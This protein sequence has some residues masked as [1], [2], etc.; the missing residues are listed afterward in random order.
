MA[1]GLTVKAIEERIDR[2]ALMTG[3]PA[4]GRE[5][6]AGMD[7]RLA[8]VAGRVARLSQD[9]KARVID[10]AP[11]GSAQ[12]RGSSWDEIIRRAGLIDGVVDL[13]SDEWGQVPLSKEMILQ[14]DPDILILP[15]WVFGDPKGA[16]AFYAQVV[17]DPALQGL[18]AVKNRKVYPMPENL[19]SAVSQYI[20]SSV[21]WLARTAYPELFP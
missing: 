19:R 7:A 11:W 10:Y 2:L 3:E 16:S 4:K 12:G 14:L 17:G 18:A 6:I 9:K 8:A 20:A 21:E 15:G 1:S 5:L 13:T